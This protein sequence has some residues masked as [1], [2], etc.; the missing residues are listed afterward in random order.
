MF[1]HLY[2]ASIISVVSLAI[3]PRSVIFR[4]M[5]DIFGKGGYIAKEQEQCCYSCGKGGASGCDHDHSDEHFCSCG[6]FGCI[7]RDFTKV[8]C[9]RGEETDRISIDCSKASEVSYYCFSESGSLTQNARHSPIIFLC[10]PLFFWSRDI[11]FSES[12]LLGR[13]WQ[14]EAVHWPVSFTYSVKGGKT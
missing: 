3:L 13:G 5:P 7:Q 14:K 1:S 12:S 10:C 8:K 2:Q 4:R 11:I 6:K 9:C